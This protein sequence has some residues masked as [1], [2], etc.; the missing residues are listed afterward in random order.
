ER[1][2]FEQVRAHD[3]DFVLLRQAAREVRAELCDAE[4]GRRFAE[5]LPGLALRLRWLGA[6]SPFAQAWTQPTEG[7]AGEVETPAEALRRRHAPLRGGGGARPGGGA[8]DAG[9]GGAAPP[10]RSRRRR[11]P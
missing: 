3:P 8:G 2:L 11:G 1:V 9:A 5:A 7:G 4:A 6:A 10:H